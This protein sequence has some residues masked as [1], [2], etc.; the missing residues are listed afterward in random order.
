MTSDVLS[1]LCP[2]AGSGIAASNHWQGETD[3]IGTNVLIFGLAAQLA[4]FTLFI[5]VL[6]LFCQRVSSGRGEG[7]GGNTRSDGL[8]SG[9]GSAREKTREFGFNP[10]HK[11]VVKGMWIAAVF[12]EVSHPIVIKRGDADVP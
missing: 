10:L 11:Q 6:A 7:D 2:G 8:L 3:K 5:I 1:F 9:G 12:I 4:T